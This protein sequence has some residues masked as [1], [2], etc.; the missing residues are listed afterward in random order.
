MLFGHHLEAFLLYSFNNPGLFKLCGCFGKSTYF[1][2]MKPFKEHHCK[3][4]AKIRILCMQTW[5]GHP[6]HA[7]R[8]GGQRGGGGRGRQRTNGC[9]VAAEGGAGHLIGVKQWNRTENGLEFEKKVF[10]LKGIQIGLGQLG[11]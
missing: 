11:A 3:R 10:L 7:A 8:H 1:P 2:F 5:Y 4:I 6:A 9:K